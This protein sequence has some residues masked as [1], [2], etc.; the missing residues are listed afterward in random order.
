MLDIDPVSGKLHWTEKFILLIPDRFD[1]AKEYRHWAN[2][3]HRLSALNKDIGYD[4]SNRGVLMAFDSKEDA[5]VFKL[6]H[7]PLDQKS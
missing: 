4:T 1:R 5:M 3:W 2:D 6:T 7:L